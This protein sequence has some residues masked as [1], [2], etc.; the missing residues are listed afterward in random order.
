VLD[1]L[2]FACGLAV[3]VSFVRN[4]QRIEPFTHD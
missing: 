2:L 1:G 4:A 3:M